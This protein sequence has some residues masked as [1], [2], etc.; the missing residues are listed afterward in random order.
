[1]GEFKEGDEVW[2]F[3]GYRTSKF[4]GEN[5]NG[6]FPRSLELEKGTIVYINE[7]EDI[8]HVYVR[9][10]EWGIARFGYTFIENYVFKTKQDAINA[11]TAQLKI[12]EK[13]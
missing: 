6:V 8:V 5:E 2:F 3:W 10:C 11:M 1:M 4:W 12:L 13:K 7:N 9:G